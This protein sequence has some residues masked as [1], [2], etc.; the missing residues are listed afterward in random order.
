MVTFEELL[1]RQ[2]IRRLEKVEKE[3]YTSFHFNN[4]RLDLRSAVA[5]LALGN[6]KYAVI[7]GYYSVLNITLWY[8]AKYFNLKISEEDVGVHKNCLVVLERYIKEEKL[9]KRIL[10]LLEEAQKEYLSFTILKKKKEETLPLLLKQSAD[11]RKKYTYY[12][13][14]RDLPKDSEQLD[15]AKNFLENTVKPY[16]FLMERIKC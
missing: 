1:Q 5:F 4:Y 12:S 13:P 11:K 2:L 10:D 14:E 9:K 6:A 3:R 16:L 7:A 8:F 15:E